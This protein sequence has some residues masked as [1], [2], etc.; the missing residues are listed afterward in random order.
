MLTTTAET[1]EAGR[2]P[3]PAAWTSAVQP[4]P[5]G[6]VV[7]VSTSLAGG[8]GTKVP[9][10]T[11]GAQDEGSS[12]GLDASTCSGLLIWPATGPPGCPHQFERAPT[13]TLEFDSSLASRSWGA[14]GTGGGG[15]RLSKM[16]LSVM[17]SAVPA[18]GASLKIPMPPEFL[19]IV[20]HVIVAPTPSLMTTA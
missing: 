15:S 9:C 1:P 11:G 7:R 16:L 17:V 5:T 4:G 14:F 10:M 3:W 18:V 2:P 13:G 19:V 20:S 12:S 8:S 6:L